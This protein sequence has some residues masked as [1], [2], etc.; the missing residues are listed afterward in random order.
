MIIFF[1]IIWITFSIT[2][3]LLSHLSNICHCYKHLH[4]IRIYKNICYHMV[5]YKLKTSNKVRK[6]QFDKN[7]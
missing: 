4:S 5:K 3:D 1:S 7:N 2:T 6:E